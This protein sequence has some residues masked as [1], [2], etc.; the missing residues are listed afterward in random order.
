MPLATG[1]TLGEAGMAKPRRGVRVPLLLRPP[2]IGGRSSGAG[3]DMVADG[4]CGLVDGW[5]EGDC[6]NGS[7]VAGVIEV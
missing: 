2:G 1:F 7:T 6:L 3:E 5:W 4:G